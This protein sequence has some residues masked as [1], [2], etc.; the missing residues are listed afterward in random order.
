MAGLQDTK[1]LLLPLPLKE[2]IMQLIILVKTI[3][4]IVLDNIGLAKKFI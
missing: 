4:R 3:V 1:T 2:L